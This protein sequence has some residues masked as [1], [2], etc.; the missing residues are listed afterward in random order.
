MN[1]TWL[2][3]APAAALEKITPRGLRWKGKEGRVATRQVPSEK[4]IGKMKTQYLLS[5]LSAPGQTKYYARQAAVEAE[6]MAATAAAA[7]AESP[8]S[9]IAPQDQM[10]QF[11]AKS[12][13]HQARIMERRAMVEEFRRIA[14]EVPYGLQG[15]AQKELAE[16]YG[17]KV[18]KIRRYAAKHKGRLLDLED[19]RFEQYRSK[20]TTEIKNDII[21]QI[22]NKPWLKATHIYKELQ[23]RF[24][25]NFKDG[26]VRDFMAKWKGKKHEL[27]CFMTNPDKHKNLYPFS[28]GSMSEK[29]THFMHYLEMDSTPADVMCADGKRYT[30]IVAIDIFSR[31][32]MVRVW[33]VSNRWGIA[34][35]FREVVLKWGVPEFLIKDNGQDYMS[36]HITQILAAFAIIAPVLPVFTPEAKPF[37]E[38][39]N[40]TMSHG[41]LP[42]LEGYI[43]YHVAGRKDIE[44]QKTFQRRLMEKGGVIPLGCTHEELQARINQW[45][46]EE[47]HQETH[48]GEGMGICPEAKAAQ[49]LV[50]ARRV[51][52]VAAL[53]LVLLPG[54]PRILSKKGVKVNGVTYV[55]PDMA[56]SQKCPVIVK[57]DPKD[58]AHIWVFETNGVFKFETWAASAKKYTRAEFQAAKNQQKKILRAEVRA[59][60]TA[61]PLIQDPDGE[62][63]VRKQSM[64]K[65]TALI[66][67]TPHSTAALSEA[68]RAAGGMGQEPLGQRLLR[69]FKETCTG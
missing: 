17:V 3:E 68:Q 11:Q 62:I 37:V 28:P 20:L 25:L 52:D 57:E 42:R 40:K 4:Q 67:N 61:R 51:V 10:A 18:S 60:E 44:A 63:R 12:P 55:N 69:E 26:A 39:F 9:S 19:K 16:R 41:I 65:V 64:K 30:L 50:P 47:Y 8:V 33:P 49:S 66:L 2:D 34:S 15:A 54:E 1:K 45:L 7:I 21:W 27:L 5:S 46:D 14:I 22:K 24:D 23:A 43:S 48:R 32:A 38:S 13:K 6:R 58:A 31:K 56:F 53:D 35:L 36:K 29:A 59:I